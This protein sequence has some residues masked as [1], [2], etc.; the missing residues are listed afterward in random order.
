MSRLL[1]EPRMIFSGLP[2]R[3]ADTALAFFQAEP[4]NRPPV[5]PLPPPA[6][7]VPIDKIPLPL[8]SPR[9]KPPRSARPFEPPPI[10]PLPPRP[11]PILPTPPGYKPPPQLTTDDLNE[12]LEIVIAMRLRARSRPRF[13]PPPYQRPVPEPLP[14]VTLRPRREAP[15][16]QR[17]VPEPNPIRPS[18]P[19]PPIQ[20]P[21]PPTN[22]IPP[23][24]PPSKVSSAV[25]R[26]LGDPRKVE[27]SFANATVAASGSGGS[28]STSPGGT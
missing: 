3:Q 22:Q 15:P 11:V 9:S 26:I 2:A 25:R 12:I 16:P 6:K 17:E 20:P 14:P 13:E 7:R 4:P 18:Q 5:V 19:T 10:E 21:L 8:P 24:L 1:S 23:P 27:S 28:P